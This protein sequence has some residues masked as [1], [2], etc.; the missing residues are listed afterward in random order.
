MINKHHG[1]FPRN[2]HDSMTTSRIIR[3]DSRLIF[4][5]EADVH[6][7][8]HRN[9]SLVPVLSH[10]V[11]MR[12]Y[13]LF[14]QEGDLGDPIKNIENWQRSIEEAIKHPRADILEQHIGLLAVH[15]YDLQKPYIQEGTR[16]E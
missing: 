1:N 10:Y 5:I 14:K 15:A 12:A 16:Y 4:P 2:Q 9:V 13:S 8:L 7:E 3:A 6:N 11:G